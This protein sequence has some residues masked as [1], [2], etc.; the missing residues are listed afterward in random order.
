MAERV[1]PPGYVLRRRPETCPEC[2]GRLVVT[3]CWQVSC[4]GCSAVFAV[5]ALFPFLLPGL[6]PLRPGEDWDGE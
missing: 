5:S 3:G 4:G 6:E 2:G 1:E